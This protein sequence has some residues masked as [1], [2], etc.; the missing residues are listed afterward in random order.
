MDS[1]EFIKHRAPILDVRSPCEFVHA[2]IPGAISFP[3]FSDKERAAVGTLYK[4]KGRDAAVKLGLHFVGPNLASFVEKAEKLASTEKTLRIYCARGGMRSSSLAWLLETAGFKCILLKGGY[5]TFRNWCLNQFEHKYNL[6]V[7][8]GLTGCGKTEYLHKLQ[9]EGEQVIDLEV[10]ANH[11]G[12][13]YGHLGL[14]QQPSAEQFENLLAVHL[15]GLNRNIRCWI[16]DESRM[17][18]KCPIPCSLINQMKEAPFVWLE[19][20]K[21]ERIQR[22]LSSY[23]THA[24]DEIIQATQRLEKKLGSVR[25]REVIEAVGVGEMEKAI[26]I[27]VDY[28][29]QAYLY[30]CKRQNRSPKVPG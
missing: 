20:S 25:T 24:P 30:S 15:S 10:I 12:S 18:G 16:E 4:K 29:D 21:E 8:G 22:L 14:S 3:L 5:K 1:E 9:L 13:S 6:Q 28:Y 26:S 2:H 19:C 23:G 17:I 11:R 7:L 27:V